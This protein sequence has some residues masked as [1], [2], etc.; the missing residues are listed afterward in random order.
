[1]ATNVGKSLKRHRLKKRLKAAGISVTKPRRKPKS[2]KKAKRKTKKRKK[3]KRKKAKRKTK[4]RKTKKRA[5]S[6]RGSQKKSRRQRPGLRRAKRA[7]P[8]ATTRR[9]PKSWWDACVKGVEESGGAVDPDAVCGS[10]WF[11]KM[12]PAERKRAKRTAYG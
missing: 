6:S 7:V 2:R 12:T 1:M 10:L 9:P 4:K 3:A 5:R 11:Q 8:G